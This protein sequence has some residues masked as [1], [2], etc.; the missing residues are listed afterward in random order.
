MAAS[1]LFDL[2]MYFE[3]CGLHR[4]GVEARRQVS[5]NEVALGIGRGLAFPAGAFMHRHDLGVGY[6]AAG[7]VSNVAQHLGGVGLRLQGSGEA[8][9]QQRADEKPQ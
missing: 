6:N 1:S 9:S 7:G 2:V 4:D 3:A 8:N 5:Q